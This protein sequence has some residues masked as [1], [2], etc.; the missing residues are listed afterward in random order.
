MGGTIL[1]IVALCLSGA[2]MLLALGSTGLFS[3]AGGN[4]VATAAAIAVLALIVGPRWLRTSRALAAERLERARA[5]ERAELG[6][7][8]HD[9]V[10]QTLALIQDRSDDPTEVAALA[11]RQERE[12]RAWLLDQRLAADRPAR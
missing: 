2:A 12:L 3:E 10:L 9:S 4:I 1:W 7:M 6:G 8:L 11:R 5:T